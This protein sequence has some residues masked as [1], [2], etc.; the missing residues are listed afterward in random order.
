MY[1][2]LYTKLYKYEKKNGGP[3]SLSLYQGMPLVI[4]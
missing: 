1:L 2:K 4:C 3:W